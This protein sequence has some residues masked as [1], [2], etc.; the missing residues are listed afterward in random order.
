MTSAKIAFSR[1]IM[2]G[3]GRNWSYA[4]TNFMILGEIFPKCGKPLDALLREK[5]LGRWPENTN[6]S[7]TSEIPSPILPRSTLNAGPR[8]D[9]FGRCVSPRNQTFWNPAMGDANRSDETTTIDDMTTT[10][11]KVWTGALMSKSSYEP[12]TGP[13][14]LWFVRSRITARPRAARKRTYTTTAWGSCARDR[15]SLQNPLLGGLG[16]D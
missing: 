16:C 3:R 12:M 1:P 10:A 13:H 6:A 14:L 8:S 11:V 9:P 5:V 4:H 15:G 7:Q 2:F